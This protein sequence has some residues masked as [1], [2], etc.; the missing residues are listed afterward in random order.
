MTVITAVMAIARYNQ[1][2]RDCERR[3]DAVHPAFLHDYDE[4]DSTE[5]NLCEALACRDMLADWLIGGDDG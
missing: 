5:R 2:I 3:L 1:I 4:I